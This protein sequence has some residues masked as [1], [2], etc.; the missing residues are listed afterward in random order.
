MDQARAVYTRILTAAN[1]TLYERLAAMTAAGL[2]VK[3]ADG[4][5]L[6]AP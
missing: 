6:A 4:Y 5:C 1:T 3:S 2:V